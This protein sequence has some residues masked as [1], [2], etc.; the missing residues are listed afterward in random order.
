MDSDNAAHISNL[1]CHN[2]NIYHSPL[3]Y[4]FAFD[5]KFIV[6][7][8]LFSTCVGTLHDVK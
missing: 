8:Q 2:I 6:L 7:Q 5:C 4:H 3:A 1:K